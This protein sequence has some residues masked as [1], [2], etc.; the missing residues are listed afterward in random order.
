MVRSL[1]YSHVVWRAAQARVLWESN[2][3]PLLS[4]EAQAQFT[5]ELS[6][7]WL[8]NASFELLFQGKRDGMTPASFQRLCYHKGPTLLLLRMQEGHVLG[9]YVAGSW[10]P[11]ATDA[12]KGAFQ[13]CVEGPRGNGVIRFPRKP[14]AGRDVTIRSPA[15]TGPLISGGME[16]RCGKGPCCT[17]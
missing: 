1:R 13:F 4:E 2:I 9:A 5:R 7:L 6:E 14:L 8:P 15:G 11:D 17:D 3:L 12:G 10:T 16:V